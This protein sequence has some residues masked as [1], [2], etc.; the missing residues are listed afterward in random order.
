MILISWHCNS[1]TK[2]E[3]N[4][5]YIFIIGSTTSK[6]IKPSSPLSWSKSIIPLFGFLKLFPILSLWALFFF[7]SSY[8]LFLFF[9]TKPQMAPFFTIK[10]KSL[11]KLIKCVTPRLLPVIHFNFAFPSHLLM[12]HLHGKTRILLPLLVL[13]FIHSKIFQYPRIH[14]VFMEQMVYEFLNSGTFIFFLQ[15]TT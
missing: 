12:S 15:I 2:F 14:H 10:P 3:Q 9:L 6:L 11:F 4:P 1:K 5:I 7:W 8:I 13:V